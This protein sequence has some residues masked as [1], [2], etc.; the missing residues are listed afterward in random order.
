MIGQV[1]RHKP[2]RATCPPLNTS[3]RSGASKSRPK[4]GPVNGSYAS[5]RWRS[6][7]CKARPAAEPRGDE[8]EHGVREDVGAGRTHVGK[9]V[10]AHHNRPIAGRQRGEDEPIGLDG[11]L[12]EVHDDDSNQCDTAGSSTPVSANQSCGQRSGPVFRQCPRDAVDTK[13]Y[14][15]LKSAG[16]MTLEPPST[17]ARRAKGIECDDP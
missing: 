12:R 11:D 7:N 5:R 14:A 1:A 2:R 10:P 8:L 3:P 16:H 4:G 17:I 15:R 13:L 6:W 9:T